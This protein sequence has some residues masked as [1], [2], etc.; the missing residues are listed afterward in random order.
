[1]KRSISFL[2]LLILLFGCEEDQSIIETQ[3]IIFS[4]LMGLM[5]KDADVIKSLA[6]GQLL[7]ETTMLGEPQ[8]IFTFSPSNLTNETN[9]T[10]L[11]SFNGGKVDKIS[12]TDMNYHSQQDLTYNLSMLADAETWS[13]KDQHTL[14]Y[15]AGSYDNIERFGNAGA[16]WNF[17][18]NEDI[19]RYN[20]KL[21]YS[22]WENSSDLLTLSYMGEYNDAFLGTIEPSGSKKSTPDLEELLE[23]LKAR[24]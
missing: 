11:Y 5:G 22:E 3:E 21:A 24:F 20:I 13:I 19:S 1:M 6:P 16:L 8:L 4:D 2:L 15:D 12:F 18:K 10:F 17:I 7:N 9:L 14:Y 23:K